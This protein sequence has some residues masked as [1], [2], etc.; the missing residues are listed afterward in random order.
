MPCNR[1]R[2]R[3]K[4]GLSRLREY[5]YLGEES[6]TLGDVIVTKANSTEP[7]TNDPPTLPPKL[8]TRKCNVLPKANRV[9]GIPLSRS[10]HQVLVAEFGRYAR[11]RLFH[12]ANSKDKSPQSI[13]QTIFSSIRRF[14]KQTT[15]AP[16]E[17]AAA[18]AD[19]SAYGLVLTSASLKFE[20]GAQSL[21]IGLAT[22]LNMTSAPSTMLD[23]Q[24]VQHDGAIDSPATSLAVSFSGI[25]CSSRI[26][27]NVI[28]LVMEQSIKG[29]PRNAPARRRL[30]SR[31][32]TEV[33]AQIDSTDIIRECVSNAWATLEAGQR[34]W[35]TRRLMDYQVDWADEAKK[36][37]CQNTEAVSTPNRLWHGNLKTVWEEFV[38]AVQDMIPA[39]SQ[40]LVLRT[41]REPKSW[42][43]ISY[44]I[45]SASENLKGEDV[46]V[47]FMGSSRR[48]H[49][50]LTIDLRNGGTFTSLIT[51][52]RNST[53]VKVKA[54]E[55]LHDPPQLNSRK[56]ACFLEFI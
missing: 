13:N 18:T 47:N 26:F 35:L 24:S 23:D 2:V 31:G 25:G 34:Q 10:L 5:S 55:L 49:E 22:Y 44:T 38:I 29:V 37:N 50:Q 39:W 20:P 17:T 36:S 53:P 21:L 12:A 52:G 3:R 45:E 16:T 8:Q 27:I 30:K 7:G 15:P 1:N 56:F 40:C 14:P 6:G 28:S 46:V 43:G 19:D 11:D 9:E 51:W 4:I 32:A 42:G 54:I 41:K 48:Q 33:I